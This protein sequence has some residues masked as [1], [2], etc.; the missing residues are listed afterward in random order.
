MVDGTPASP[1][2][3]FFFYQ[4]K[5]PAGGCWQVTGGATAT[6]TPLMLNGTCSAA[7]GTANT[8]IETCG[9]SEQYFYFQRV[10][11]STTQ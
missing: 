4:I 2:A 9:D 6:G 7:S 3:Y 1:A 10:A 5:A 11:G 8:G